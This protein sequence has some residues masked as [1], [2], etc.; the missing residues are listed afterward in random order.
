MD[1]LPFPSTFFLKELRMSK[2]SYLV[3]MRVSL[4]Y[5]NSSSTIML[6]K[7]D[8]SEEYSKLFIIASLSLKSFLLLLLRISIRSYSMPMLTKV[9]QTVGFGIEP[10]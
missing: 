1:Y 4:E 5:F 6:I 8:L 10:S 2:Q 7:G 3:S 9:S